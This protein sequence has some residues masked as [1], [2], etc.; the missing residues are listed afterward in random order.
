MTRQAQDALQFADS[1]DEATLQL[2]SGRPNLKHKDQAALL[3]MD[4]SKPSPFTN[5]AG[6]V[7]Q[8]TLQK[9]Y[10][11]WTMQGLIH[12]TPKAYLFLGKNNFQAWIPKAM[13]ED[14]EVLD[15]S[16]KLTVQ[17]NQIFSVTW[18]KRL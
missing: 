5:R 16:G 3:D 7:S 14:L 13:C 4:L 15:N 18:T 17:V 2:D 9:Y 1:Y 11:K 12:E 6:N 8:N 10:T